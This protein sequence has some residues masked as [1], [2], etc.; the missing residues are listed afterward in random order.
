MLTAV[1]RMELNNRGVGGD[2]S[3]VNQV[4]EDVKQLHEKMENMIQNQNNHLI[5]NYGGTMAR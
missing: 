3:Q 5:A 4:M 2:T 1:F